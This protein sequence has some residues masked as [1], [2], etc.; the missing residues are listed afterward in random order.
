MITSTANAQIKHLIQLQKKGKLRTEQGI[1]VSEGKKMFEEAK[2]LDGQIIK[3]YFSESFAKTQEAETGQGIENYA[4]GIPYEIVQDSVFAVCAETMTPQGILA[5]VRQPSYQLED[6]LNQKQLRLLLLENL[7]DP[8]NLGTIFRTAEGAGTTGIILS[9][10]SVDLFNPKVIRS[11][12][13]SVFRVPFVYA[14]DFL[15]ILNQLKASQ[16]Q[17]FAAHLKGSIPYNTADYRGNTAI[18]IGNEANGLSAESTKA[19][20][21]AVRIPMGGRLES[22][23]AAVAAAILMYERA[24]QLNFS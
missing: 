24:R 15:G 6:L 18:L 2:T 12:M 20:S 3:A 13:G 4:A 5:M 14:E 22:L 23:N 1:F 11:T 21:Q 19:A 9:Q 8:G 17:I 16:V 10:E 7:R